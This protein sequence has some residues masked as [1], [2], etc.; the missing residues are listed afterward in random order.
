MNS[1]TTTPGTKN[2][3]D[4]SNPSPVRPLAKDRQKTTQ[5]K[6][7][8]YFALSVFIYFIS[9][10]VMTIIYSYTIIKLRGSKFLFLFK[11]H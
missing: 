10:S 4:V 9:L 7:T 8:I 3:C 11:K 6:P 1:D 5:V 2:S